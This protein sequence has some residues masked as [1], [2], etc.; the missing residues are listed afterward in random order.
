[1]IDERNNKGLFHEQ[2]GNLRNCDIDSGNALKME[3][4]YKL[5]EASKLCL[6]ICGW[7]RLLYIISINFIITMKMVGVHDHG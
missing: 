1:M 2:S 3:A 4:N 5:R 6:V 7:M